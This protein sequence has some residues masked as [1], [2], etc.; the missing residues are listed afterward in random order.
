LEVALEGSRDMLT[1]LQVAK[2]VRFARVTGERR[3]TSFDIDARPLTGSPSQAASDLPPIRKKGRE[4]LRIVADKET[5][6]LMVVRN[7]R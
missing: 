3:A 1:P 7:L 4:F 2:A 6:E 5:G